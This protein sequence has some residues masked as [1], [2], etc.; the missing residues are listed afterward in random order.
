MVHSVV[1]IAMLIG[2][3]KIT[4]VERAGS[5]WRASV[6]FPLGVRRKGPVRATRSDA[7]ADA[8]KLLAERDAGANPG[9]AFTLF[10]AQQLLLEQLRRRRRRP[11]TIEAAEAQYRSLCSAWRPDLELRLLTRDSV[12]WFIDR[13]V[14]EGASAATINKHVAHLARLIDIGVR[15]G[16]IRSGIN[17]A[18]I[19]DRPAA[20]LPARVSIPLTKVKEAECVAEFIG[21]HREAL[22][23]RLLR[24]TGLRRS[25]AAALRVQDIRHDLGVLDIHRPKVAAQPRQLALTPAL[26]ECLAQLVEFAGDD[27]RLFTRPDDITLALRKIARLVNEPKLRAHAIRHGVGDRVADG[28]GGDITAIARVLGHTP[29]SVRMTMRYAQAAD[30]RLREAQRLLE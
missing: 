10:D 4:N 11:G 20:T 15:E 6:Y 23:I 7:A 1:H 8:E 28:T 29:G 9:S 5:G 14:G 25:E 18:R 27:G 13:R 16:R 17:P 26:A 12:H 2:M 21:K 24:L 3:R 22:T 30:Q 19:A